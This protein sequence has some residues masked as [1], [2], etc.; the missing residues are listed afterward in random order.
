MNI[1]LGASGQIGWAIVNK[2]LQN[3]KPVKAIIRDPKKV[4]AFK[5]KGIPVE[6]ADAFDL[7]ALIKAFSDGDTV[8]LLTP[9]NPQSTNVIGETELLLKNYREAIRQSGIKK[10]VGLSSIGAQHKSGTGNLAMSYMLEHA[11]SDMSLKQVFI[12][13]SYYYSNWMA[14]FEIV[15]QQSVLPT[16][17]PVDFKLPMAA[18]T[19]VAEF[20]A[21]MIVDGSRQRKI[22]E[23]VGPAYS[24]AEVAAVF[25]QVLNCEVTA[26]QI[27]EEKWEETLL[28]AGFSK[29]AATNMIEM[30]LAVI[31]GKAQPETAE[32][33]RVKLSTSLQ[34]YLKKI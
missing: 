3:K 19:E 26:Q 31:N 25:G 15:K 28:Q 20:A 2:L 29:N 11:F 9:E 8:F 6:I 18:P 24:S 4:V 7:Q 21:S 10:I 16:F 14:Y 1:V 33:Y 23:L 17:F 22:Y 13:P 5:N 12:R 34:T 27:P 32:E 30:T